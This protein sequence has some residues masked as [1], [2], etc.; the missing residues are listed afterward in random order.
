MWY[1]YDHDINTSIY[2]RDEALQLANEQWDR[3]LTLS[4]TRERVRIF[5]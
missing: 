1:R 5:L 4:A 3:L 2:I